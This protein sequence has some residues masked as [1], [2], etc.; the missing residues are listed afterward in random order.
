MTS[1]RCTISA[2]FLLLIVAVA[3]CGRDSGDAPE[4][5]TTSVIDSEKPDT[6]VADTAESDSSLSEILRQAE[7]PSEA[8]PDEAADEEVAPPVEDSPPA[9]ASLSGGYRLI[10]VNG[11]ILPVVL[12]EG[13]ECDVELVRGDVIIRDDRTFDLQTASQENCDGDVRNEQTHDAVGTVV[14]DGDRLR[15]D[16]TDGEAFAVAHGQLVAGGRILIDR[17]EFEGGEHEVRWEFVR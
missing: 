6:S 15:F 9:A 12:V 16:A 3:G 8:A 4:P 13:P 1:T 10:R 11:D 14:R 17:L 5:D 7:P 2:A